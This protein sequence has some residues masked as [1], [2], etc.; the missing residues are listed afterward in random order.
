MKRI[1]L[2]INLCLLLV[3]GGNS[4][5]AATPNVVNHSFSQ[6]LPERQQIKIRTTIPSTTLI[7]ST[8]IDLDEEFHN[9]DEFAKTSKQLVTKNGLLSNWY[10]T[11][12]SQTI[13]KEY[14]KRI[15][16]FAPFCGYSNPIY[17]RQQ[18]LRI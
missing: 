14:S 12:S 9:S 15:K 7:E 11:F 2:Y 16:I 13:S 10:L 1:V 17:I 6:I 4:L 5:F 3:A 8:D 18:V